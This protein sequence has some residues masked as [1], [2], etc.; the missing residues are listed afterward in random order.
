MIVQPN[1][2]ALESKESFLTLCS[3]YIKRE[4]I[5]DLM[6]WLETTDFFTAPASTRYHLSREGGLCQHSINVFNSLVTVMK[7]FGIKTTRE[8]AAIITL[9]HDICKADT[10]KVNFRN[11]KDENGQW[12]KVPYF[13]FE[14]QFCYGSH[15]GKSVFLIQKFM[16]LSDEEAVAI[17]CHMG[18]ED[19]KYTTANAYK[20][21]PLAWALHVA[22]EAATYITEK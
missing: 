18:N 19:G 17:N 1:K 21:Y 20:Q 9:F 3:E 8:T 13:A 14:E 5:F 16:P 15:G 12:Q 6:G 22:D 10:Y 4:G 11:A 2:D 7:A